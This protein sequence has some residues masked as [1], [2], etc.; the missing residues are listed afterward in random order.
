MKTIIFTLFAAL[1]AVGAVS[2][3][4]FFFHSF[5][6]DSGVDRIATDFNWNVAGA[7][8]GT[9]NP[10]WLTPTNNLNVSRGNNYTEAEA[11]VLG[12]PGDAFRGRG[13]LFGLVSDGSTPG[14]YVKYIAADRKSV[15]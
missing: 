5:N 1:F 3:H 7:P 10:D 14:A 4:T 9:L 8:D 12:R 11:P 6:N 13:F 15:V 2:G